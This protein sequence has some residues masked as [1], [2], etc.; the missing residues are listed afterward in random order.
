LRQGLLQLL[1]SARVLLDQLDREEGGRV[2]LASVITE[3]E[4]RENRWCILPEE[5]RDGELADKR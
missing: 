1:C 4:S 2:R 3:T 5:N